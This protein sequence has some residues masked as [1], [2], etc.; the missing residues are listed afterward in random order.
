LGTE[1]GDPEMLFRGWQYRY[2]AAIGDGRVAVAEASL[3]A[4]DD[5]A[6]RLRQPAFVW[7]AGYHR[8]A[9]LLLQ[10]NLEEAESA[11]RVAFEAAQVGGPLAATA[12]RFYEMAQLTAIRWDQGQIAE[13]VARWQW[14]A[15]TQPTRPLMKAGLAFVLCQAGNLDEGRPYFEVAL[16]ELAAVRRDFDWVV[17]VCLEI[18]T[19]AKLGEAH[20]L[21]PLYDRLLPLAGRNWWNRNGSWGPVDLYLGILA[22]ARGRFKA[23]EQHFK[24][25]ADLARRL[26]APGWLSRVEVQRA[27][28]LLQRGAPGDAEGGRQL[29]RQALEQSERLGL[30]GIA[31]DA[32]SVLDASTPRLNG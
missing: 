18:L 21:D 4:L 14:A 8:A 6:S 23:A 2:A 24:V 25:A 30:D 11:S 20:R 3:A 17:T 32:R 15:E 12:F 9:H 31:D 13:R 10:G 22:G 26:Q 27:K 19:G 28:M 7:T 1:L 5:L 16:Q 29:A